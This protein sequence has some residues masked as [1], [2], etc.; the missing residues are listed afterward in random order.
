MNEIKYRLLGKEHQ[1]MYS[2]EEILD[3]HSLKDTLKYSGEETEYYSPLLQYTGIKDKNG[4]GI[5]AGDI[6]KIDEDWEEVGFVGY[7]I[8]ELGAFK[9]KEGRIFVLRYRL[10]GSFSKLATVIGNIYENPELVKN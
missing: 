8:Y 2:W 6:I 7:V 3:F 10:D 1:I 9:L 5:Y 4:K